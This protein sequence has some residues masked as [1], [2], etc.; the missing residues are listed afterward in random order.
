MIVELDEQKSWLAFR[1]SLEKAI[2]VPLGAYKE[3]QMKRRLANI[4]TR[5]KLNG[6]SAFAEALKTPAVLDDVRDTLT[7]NVSEF[8]R[9]T[10]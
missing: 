6:W 8:Y 5:S 9:Q 4:M 10:D 7:I 3:P 2:G 1:A